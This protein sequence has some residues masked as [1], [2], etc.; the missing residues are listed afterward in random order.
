MEFVERRETHKVEKETGASAPPKKGGASAAR[1]TETERLQKEL[2]RLSSV[3]REEEIEVER[4]REEKRRHWMQTKK[5]NAAFPRKKHPRALPF[6]SSGDG[7][8]AGT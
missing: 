7:K 4:K 2:R 8:F 3:R 1:S 5:M 6:A